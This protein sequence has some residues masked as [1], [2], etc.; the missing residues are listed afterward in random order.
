MTPREQELQRIRKCA[1]PNLLSYKLTLMCIFTGADPERDVYDL[2]AR[3]VDTDSSMDRQRAFESFKIPADYV[4]HAKSLYRVAAAGELGN[5]YRIYD[6]VAGIDRYLEEVDPKGLRALK[7]TTPFKFKL[8]NV[9]D[10]MDLE[11]NVLT[12]RL[13]KYCAARGQVYDVVNSGFARDVASR[14]GKDPAFRAVI[15]AI[16]IGG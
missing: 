14:Y 6:L 9:L 13:A 11:E 10:E 8:L 2:M 5:D 12:A 16:D 7:A 1:S 4:D 3:F 15:D